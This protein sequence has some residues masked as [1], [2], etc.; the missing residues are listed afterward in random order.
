MKGK[1]QDFSNQ[2]TLFFKA[3][4]DQKTR[5]A[6]VQISTPLVPTHLCWIPKSPCDQGQFLTDGLSLDILFVPL[7]CTCLLHHGQFFW[8]TEL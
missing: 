4:W 2:L 8:A 7:S 6:L 3:E 1:K 5:D